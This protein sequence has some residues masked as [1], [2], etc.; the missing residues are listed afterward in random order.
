MY[1]M[2]TVS[3]YHLS[4]CSSVSR[5]VS[6]FEHGWTENQLRVVALGECGN[7]LLDGSFDR[8][9]D[10]SHSFDAAFVKLLCPLVIPVINVWVRSEQRVIWLDSP[11]VGRR[12]R[13]VRSQ[14][15]ASP[16][17]SLQCRVQPRWTTYCQRLVWQVRPHLERSG[18]SPLL[19]CRQRAMH[20][21]WTIAIE[22]PT[23]SLSC[24][25]VAELC[26]NGY[27]NHGPVWGGAKK[28]LGKRDLI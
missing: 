1:D 22:A 27:M 28:H 3:T 11:I 15:H 8:S 26:K 5:V 6:L 12:T 24:D 18:A 17:A 16:G 25:H 20:D 2:P 4:V 13:P 19:P 14:T 23:V 9:P 10:Y 21:M 7:I